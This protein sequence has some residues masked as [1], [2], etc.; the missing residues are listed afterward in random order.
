MKFG[1]YGKWVML[2][3]L[4]YSKEAPTNIEDDSLENVIAKAST[5]I[6]DEKTHYLII[7]KYT[8]GNEEYFLRA[9]QKDTRWV[10]DLFDYRNMVS[11]GS[12]H[13]WCGLSQLDAKLSELILTNS[14]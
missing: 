7:K 12:S 8:N 13:Y 9:D 3:A 14:L 10:I 1:D 11:S 5:T 6:R 2:F 4:S